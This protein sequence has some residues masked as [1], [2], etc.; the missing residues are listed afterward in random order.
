MS[1]SVRQWVIKVVQVSVVMHQHRS[2]HPGTIADRGDGRRDVAV[3]ILRAEEPADR[4]RRRSTW[5][6]RCTPASTLCRGRLTTADCDT[7][8]T[9]KLISSVRHAT[10]KRSENT[11]SRGGNQLCYWRPVRLG[12]ARTH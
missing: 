2:G 9:A 12:Q 5:I 3:G 1:V 4:T 10:G 6:P 8:K 7:A 11:D